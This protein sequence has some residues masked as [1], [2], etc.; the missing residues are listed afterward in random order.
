MAKA[1][2]N[3]SSLRKGCPLFSQSSLQRSRAQE[4]LV[5][6][7]LHASKPEQFCAVATEYQ[8]LVE[9]L[10]QPAIAR[11]Y[12][13]L[14]VLVHW[15]QWVSATALADAAGVVPRTAK[16]ALVVLERSGLIRRAGRGPDGSI[17]WHIV[18][19]SWPRKAVRVDVDPDVYRHAAARLR[20]EMPAAE[21]TSGDPPI[22]GGGDPP[23]TATPYR[24]D[25]DQDLRP[26][27]LPP[28]DPEPPPPPDPTD[29]GLVDH[30]SFAPV[31]RAWR[32]RYAPRVVARV[33][34]EAVARHPSAPLPGILRHFLEAAGDPSLYAPGIG[35]PLHVALNRSHAA[36]EALARSALQKRNGAPVARR[37][38]AC[39]SDSPPPLTALEQLELARLAIRMV[40]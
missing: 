32:T 26:Y 39:P 16:R 37:E 13:R 40:S 3:D 22:T 25:P 8:R 11:C 34:S 6:D 7:T 10:L 36:L 27:P 35:S 4:T 5:I 21:Q 38:T 31:A 1:R 19:S 28:P 23:I 30:P 14:V 2:G 9:P 20:G 29:G 24:S 17:E 15:R 18:R 12:A 33:V